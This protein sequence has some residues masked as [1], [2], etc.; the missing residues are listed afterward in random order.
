MTE[1]GMAG[2]LLSERHSVTLLPQ[3]CLV[4]VCW[5]EL[6]WGLSPLSPC[7]AFPSWMPEH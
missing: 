6:G 7:N 3:C 4:D 1:R 5:G 2:L